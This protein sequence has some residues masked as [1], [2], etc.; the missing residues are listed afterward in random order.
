MAAYAA[1]K[2]LSKHNTKYYRLIS[3]VRRSSKP[4]GVFFVSHFIH[5][6]PSQN[7]HIK[8]TEW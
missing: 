5:Y 2:L 6:K 3:R 1:N 4:V 7:G 8:V